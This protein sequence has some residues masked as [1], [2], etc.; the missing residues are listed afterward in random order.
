MT[1]EA[2][3]KI[4]NWPVPKCVRDVESFWGF[5]NYYRDHIH[6]FADLSASLYNLTGC[7]AVFQW[8]AQNEQDFNQ[9][10]QRLIGAPTLA[11]PNQNDLFILD[12]DASDKAIG[13][14]LSQVHNGV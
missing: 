14:V 7:K 2:T 1:Q 5:A 12:T 10:K 4:A 6:H 8:S 3:E 9:L 13:G 11:F